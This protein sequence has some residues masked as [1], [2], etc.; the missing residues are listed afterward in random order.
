[1]K[2]PNWI[3]MGKRYIDNNYILDKNTPLFNIKD[4]P[5]EKKCEILDDIIDTIEY[6]KIPK[7]YPIE[8]YLYLI[9]FPEKKYKYH[10]ITQSETPNTPLEIHFHDFII[11]P[12]IYVGETNNIE[13]LQ[14]IIDNNYGIN[15]TTYEKAILNQDLPMM[16]YLE[17]SNPLIYN[18]DD[19]LESDITC[20]T[21]ETGNF[22]IINH[23]K[24]YLNIDEIS[25]EEKLSSIESKNI[26]FI[27]KVFENENAF[28]FE[29]TNHLI[30][31]C[32]RL[33]NIEILKFF[34]DKFNININNLNLSYLLGCENVKFVKY[35]IKCFPEYKIELKDLYLYLEHSIMKFEI[36]KLLEEENVIGKIDPNRILPLCE[37]YFSRSSH[38]IYE[39]IEN[40]KMK[41][42]LIYKK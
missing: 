4:I 30:N 11:Y 32:V 25:E 18:V 29:Y 8:I 13:L 31:I 2:I 22:E 40:A 9:D 26:D 34:I 6:W 19:L 16:K 10:I 36:F 15:I 41:E 5:I 21:F 1:M 14:Y 3:K 42:Y 35:L 23:V 20:V 37:K 12:K 24:E 27:K 38:S 39:H 17:N 28:N 33:E 7:P